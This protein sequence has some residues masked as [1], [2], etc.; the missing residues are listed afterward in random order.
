MICLLSKEL[1]YEE[2]KEINLQVSICNKAAYHSSVVITQ[3]K[4]YHI[5][6]N[7]VNQSEGPRFKPAVKVISLSEDSTSIDIRKI[8]TNY[9]AIDSDTLLTA[10]DVR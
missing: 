1:D 7:V 8:I 6:V 2:L 4:T 5:K 3:S 9:A 10:T